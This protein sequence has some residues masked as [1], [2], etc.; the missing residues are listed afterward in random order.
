MIIEKKILLEC[1]VPKGKTSFGHLQIFNSQSTNTF[2]YV[3]TG[4]EWKKDS[5]K[6]P[7]IAWIA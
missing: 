1:D 3:N 5:W 4:T 6:A 2:V 7:K